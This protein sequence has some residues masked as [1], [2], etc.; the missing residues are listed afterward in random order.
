MWNKS[1]AGILCGILV[2][3]F[4]PSAFSLFFPS[5][6]AWWIA[7]TIIIGL[8]SWAGVMTWVY[9]APNG[10]KAWQRGLSCSLPCMALYGIAFL[11]M[12]LPQ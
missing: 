8:P 3:V 4:L 2:I 9:A 11:T 7:F 6:I 12:G 10:K 5:I 1:F